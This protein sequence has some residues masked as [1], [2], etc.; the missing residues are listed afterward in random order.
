MITVPGKSEGSVLLPVFEK[1]DVVLDYAGLKY[2]PSDDLIFPS[3]IKV[4]GMLPRPLATYYMYYAPHNAPGGIC[5]AYSDTLEGPWMEYGGNPLIAHIW[6]PH[7][8]VEHVSSPHALFVPEASRLFLYYHGDNDTTRYATSEDGLAFDYGGIAVDVNRFGNVSGISYA[9]AFRHAHPSRPDNYVMLFLAFKYAEDSY[10][11]FDHHGLYAAWSPDART[12]RIEQDPII[13]QSDIGPSE[14]LCSPYLFSRQ[15]RH[16]VFYHR[17][18]RDK[19]AP[20]GIRT[21]VDWVEVD[22]SLK[23]I[24]NPERL[25]ARQVFSG[26]N[27]RISDPCPVLEGDALYLFA[28]I[29]SR[30]NQRIGL[31]VGKGM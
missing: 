28:S 8:R 11:V 27:V 7:Y 10:T 17:D 22:R 30:L 13:G 16:F 26:D 29:G 25:C 5:L 24:G 19:N 15:G 2:N 21:D 6:E 9:R 12:W 18:T 3:V 4:A 1:G 23:R 14:F 31:S 20:G